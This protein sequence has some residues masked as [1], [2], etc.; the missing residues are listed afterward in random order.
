MS[1]LMI[2]GFSRLF[3]HI[4]RV[5]I[6]PVEFIST[7]FYMRLYLSLLIRMGLNIT[8][9]P[10][11]ISTKA[12]F[13]DLTLTT[14]GERTVISKHVVLLT[15]DYS[16][17]TALITLGELPA[18]DIGVSRPIV[19]GNNVFIG[20]GAIVM[21]GSCIGDNVIVGAGSVIRGLVPGDSVVIG[22][23]GAVVD[24]ISGQEARWRALSSGPFAQKDRA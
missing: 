3:M 4:I 23:P 12:R 19:I 6:V 10:R 2:R 8:G 1:R 20:M 16:V 7:R 9:T 18:T 14:L 15:H 11:Y 5:V 13:D 21:P 17:T 24:T 22:N